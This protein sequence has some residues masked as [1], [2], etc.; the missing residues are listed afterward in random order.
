MTFRNFILILL[1][2]WVFYA[3]GVPP[4]IEDFFRAILGAFT[5]LFLHILALIIKLCLSLASHLQDY[6][7]SLCSHGPCPEW[8]PPQVRFTQQAAYFGAGLFRGIGKF[9][10]DQGTRFISHNIGAGDTIGK[11]AM[12]LTVIGA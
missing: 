7:Q 5:D 2:A 11:I 1:L 8:A 6:G 4:P 9:L 10:M 12:W 3:Q